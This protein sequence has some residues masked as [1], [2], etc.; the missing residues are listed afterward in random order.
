MATPSG[1]TKITE[2]DYRAAFVMTKSDAN[3]VSADTA[4]TLGVPFVNAIQVAAA[5]NIV[6]KTPSIGTGPAVNTITITSAAVGD[7]FNFPIE[8]LMSTGTTAV[9][10]GLVR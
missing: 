5:G 3:K 4:N 7:V 1:K 8:Q 2:S 10:I 6:V 9:V